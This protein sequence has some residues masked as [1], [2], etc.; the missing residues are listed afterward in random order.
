MSLE[1]GLRVYFGTGEK[2]V[3]LVG[4]GNP[5]MGDDAVGPRI[6]ELL[7]GKNLE[8]VLLINAESVPEAF[9]EQVVQHNPTH[10]LML[11]VANFRG[12]P[13]EIRLISGEE[14]GGQAVS[15]HSLPLNIFISY[16]EESLGIK[17][18][19]LGIQPITIG[20]G[21][22]I[23]EPV[24]TSANFIVNTLCQILSK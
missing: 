16:I 11:D 13:G 6:I 4:V 24:G 14:I 2:R 21:E 8:N 23:S 10:V 22:P 20:L 17:V 9:V 18:L 7:Q 3:V 1:Q 19:L 15:S 12:K 5:M